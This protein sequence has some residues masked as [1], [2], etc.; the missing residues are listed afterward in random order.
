MPSRRNHSADQRG[1]ADGAVRLDL[2]AGILARIVL[3]LASGSV[4]LLIGTALDRVITGEARAGSWI[5][6]KALSE[7]NLATENVLATWYSSALLLTVAV[8]AGVNLAAILG[9]RERRWPVA[10]AWFAAAL[11][12]ILLSFD[13]LASMHERLTLPSPEIVTDHLKTWAGRLAVPILLAGVGLASFAFHLKRYSRKAFWLAALGLALYASVPLQ[14]EIEELFTEAATMEP[15]ERPI[16]SILLEEGAELFGSLCFIAAFGLYALARNRIGRAPGEPEGPVQLDRKITKIL[17]IGVV[18]GLVIWAATFEFAVP[19]SFTADG[20][21]IPANWFAAAP[22][23]L[24]GLVGFQAWRT[25]SAN[26]GASRLRPWMLLGVS[27]F[28]LMLSAAHGA[29]L[30]F[31]DKLWPGSPR[32]QLAVRA[33]AASTALGLASALLIWGR[34]G[35]SRIGVF[36]WGALLGLALVAHPTSAMLLLALGY[37]VLLLALQPYLI[38]G[39][40]AGSRPEAATRSD[41]ERLR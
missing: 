14:E 2:T 32:L 36:L 5:I 35:A 39:P 9:P 22:A 24:A 28:C 31:S 16:W 37:G 20:K 40:T 15:W 13:E 7:A 10:A 33:G 4:L 12:F 17:M 11:L 3:S 23:L 19:A 41:T 29:D 34:R 25:E 38:V 18:A 6:G 21:G 1:E 30:F 27:A 26:R 8:V